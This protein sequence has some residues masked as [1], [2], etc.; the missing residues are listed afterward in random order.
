MYGVP[1]LPDKIDEWERGRIPRSL[2][3]LTQDVAEAL[4]VYGRLSEAPLFHAEALAKT[5]I[6]AID[7][8]GELKLALEE[9]AVQEPESKYQGYP[10]RRGYRHPAEER[11]LGHPTLLGGGPARI[12]GELVQDDGT[13]GPHWVVNANSGRYCKHQSP[14]ER[15]LGNVAAKFKSFGLDVMVDFND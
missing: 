4:R 10:R 1:R 3:T 15:Q 8:A 14:S 5:Y 2:C 12:A 6:W 9:L 13:S 11:K 7:P